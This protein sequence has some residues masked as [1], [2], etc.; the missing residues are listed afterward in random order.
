MDSPEGAGQAVPQEKVKQLP[1]W[2][3]LVRSVLALGRVGLVWWWA[4]LPGALVAV[5]ASSAA[6]GALITAQLV[7]G[8]LLLPD[9][10][11][12]GPGGRRF[13]VG[14]RQSLVGTAGVGVRIVWPWIAA[15]AGITG[16]ISGYWRAPKVVRYERDMTRWRPAWRRLTVR[17]LPNQPRSLWPQLADQVLR[18]TNQAQVETMVDDRH[19]LVM[20]FTREPLPSFAA[21]PVDL[22]G[23]EDGFVPIGVAAGGRVF[24]WRPDETP[25]LTVTGST[26]GGK[27]VTV[28][29]IEAHAVARGWQILRANAKLT[30]ESDWLD[31]WASVADTPAGMWAMSRAVLELMNE[32]Q[33]AIKAAGVDDWTQVEGIGPRVLFIID[34]GANLISPAIRDERRPFAMATSSNITTASAMARSAG[35]HLVYQTQQPG[36]DSYGYAGSQ[37][38][39]NIGGRMIVGSSDQI[40]LREL[41]VGDLDPLVATALMSGTKGR[42]VFQRLDPTV[43]DGSVEV[44]Q[45]F[46]A[47]QHTAAEVLAGTEPTAPPVDFDTIGPAQWTAFQERMAEIESS[48]RQR[49]RKRPSTKQDNEQEAA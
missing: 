28:R 35:I 40:W 21:L 18:A 25:H 42:T 46:Y 2:R 31:G 41:F 14:S 5:V 33:A 17:M 10:E 36:V 16:A 23:R 24:G 20:T 47:P 44:G 19:H 38:R 12:K 32:R 48:G 22:L 4:T 7:V 30:G 43:G 1:W 29:N 15:H 8:S 13:R 11:I 45:V 27:G 39:L 3:R 37:V 6:L 26:G 9:L 49:R 34:E